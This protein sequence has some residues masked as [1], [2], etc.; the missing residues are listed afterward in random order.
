MPLTEVESSSHSRRR[1]LH[2]VQAPFVVMTLIVS[3]VAA[4][5]IP[6]DA[7]TPPFLT[8]VGLIISTAVTGA[9]VPWERVPYSSMML[10]AIVDLF[11]VSLLRFA[12]YESLPAI[13]ILAVFP[14]IWLAYAFHGRMMS[15]AVWASVLLVALPLVILGPTPETPRAWANVMILPV[16]LVLIVSAVR[17]AAVQVRRNRATLDRIS[18]LQ[19]EAL[20]SA[21]DSELVLRSVFDTVDAAMAFYGVNNRPVVANEAAHSTVAKL[22]FSLDHPPFAGV[23]VYRT[24]RVTQIPFD[25]QIIPRALRGERIANHVEW[26]G[27][28]GDQSAIMASAQQVHRADGELLGTVIAV[29]DITDLA[30]AIT[31]REEFLRTVSH[32]LRTPLT[33]IIGYLEVMEDSVDLEQVGLA[34][35]MEIVQRN[36][37]DLHTRVA[38]L[39]AFADNA[40][41][42]PEELTDASDAVQATVQH[43]LPVASAEGLTLTHDIE[44]AV[45]VTAESSKIRQVADHLISNAVKY[46]RRGGAVRVSLSATNGQIV[47]SVADNGRGMTPEQQ[48]QAFDRFFRAPEVRS[49]AVQG[50]GIGLSLVKEIVEAHGG[51]I[52]IDSER[53]VGTTVT[54]RFAYSRETPVIQERSVINSG[55]S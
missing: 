7:L 28:P 33:S 30:N 32:E 15:L 53:A 29:Y 22:G 3:V 12:A 20:R 1:T 51:T 52:E 18:T 34:E 27:P 41:A 25:E 23:H 14:S 37:A 26:L 16:A 35:Y 4:F 13:G 55:A 50:L 19:R 11:A 49:D 44:P 40:P 48:R 2:R 17:A 24:D 43:Y 39:L 45:L 47:F 10:L 9:L 21:Q 8:G 46:T 6:D 38:Q 54:I 5:V 31:V 42:S 36:A